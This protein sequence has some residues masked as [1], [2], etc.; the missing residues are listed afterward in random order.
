[1]VIIRATFFLIT[2]AFVQSAV[3]NDTLRTGAIYF[4]Q[5]DA[6]LT[7]RLCC[8]DGPRFFA[9]VNELL[10]NTGRVVEFADPGT[11]AVVVAIGPA[12]ALEVWFVVDSG[13]FPENVREAIKLVIQEKVPAVEEG[14][15]AIAYRYALADAEI[16]ETS[17]PIPEEWLMVIEESQ[18]GSLSTDE[19]L[20]I[21]IAA[22]NQS[23]QSDQPAAGR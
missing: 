14:P 7:E 23:V 21:L 10:L 6:V 11:G 17:L 18:Q 12:Q 16:V 1:V 15:V 19:I 2:A 3:A 20:S 8:E 5:P 9:E 13:E 22:P 4:Y